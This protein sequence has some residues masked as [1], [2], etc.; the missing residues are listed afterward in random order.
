MSP[1][2]QPIRRA[3][4][5]R[6]VEAVRAKEAPAAL[7]ALAHD[8]LSRQAEGRTFYAGPKLART[9]A[10]EHGVDRDAAE[11]EAGNLLA[12]LERG[13]DTAL[14][15]ALVAAFAVA[16]LGEAMAGDVE[17]T[18]WRFVRHADWLEVCTDYAVYPFVEPLLSEAH[19]SRVWS[20]VAQAVVDD[21]AGRESER[22]RVRARNAARL[23]ALAGARSQAAV[24]A[25]RRVV[26]SAAL[27][28]PTRLLAST[29]A[30]DGADE[31]AVLPAS[32]AG[33]LGRSPRRGVLEVLRWLSG[34]ALLS[35]LLRGLAFVLGLRR[36]AELKLADD[37]VEVHIRVSLLGKVV[38]E[39]DE[40]WRFDALERAERQVRYP[41]LPLLVGALALS[42]GVLFGGLVLFDGMRSG[43]LVLLLVAAA[44]LLGG[45]GLDLALDVLWP[46]KGGRVV[47]DL[48][49]RSRR[50]LRLT[51][52]PVEQ[53]DAFLRALR[54]RAA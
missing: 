45:A 17:R 28:E 10:E 38:R 1:E 31:A 30:G 19:A 2:A 7:A 27:D 35:W 52:V 41:A 24:E 23:T 34:W 39:G 13:A 20:E 11:T 43:E 5:E 49:G 21:A 54:N 12:I 53:A 42:V 6:A 33:R 8:V 37:G 25:L 22:P 4:V 46:A 36:T 16:G 3:D 14:E 18:V 48:A 47:V 15:R 32:V 9:R 44:L 29:L 50:P 26:R 51:R 40:T